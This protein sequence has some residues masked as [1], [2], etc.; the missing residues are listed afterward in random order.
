MAPG[1]VVRRTGGHTP[2]HGVVRLADRGDRLTFAGDAVFRVGFE[3]PD[4]TTA[5]NTTP[6]RLP[7]G[8]SVFCELAPN[9]ESLAATHL[10]PVRLP[11]GGRRRR[12]V[13]YRAPGS[14]DRLLVRAEP[15]RRTRPGSQGRPRH[16]S[17]SFVLMRGFGGNAQTN[18]VTT[19]RAP[20]S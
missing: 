15:R 1:V 12:L 14:T 10:V 13:R 7:A 20:R 19:T 9:R 6:R 18:V 5:S 11:C 4:C 3:H 8:A 2:G 17:V 16:V